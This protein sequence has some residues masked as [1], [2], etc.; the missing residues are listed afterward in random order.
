VCALL[1]AGLLVSICHLQYNHHK[2]KLVH[3][4]S[5]DQSIF[6]ICPSQSSHP[7]QLGP[8][9]YASLPHSVVCVPAIARAAAAGDKQ[10][11]T[12]T[13]RTDLS[14]FQHDD[15]KHLARSGTLQLRAYG[16]GTVQPVKTYQTTGAHTVRRRCM[17]PCTHLPGR[18]LSS[19]PDPLVCGREP[20]S[21][22]ATA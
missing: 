6:F 4:R 15:L 22:C 19:P 14:V 16:T 10:A 13:D 21:S 7:W 11:P 5:C 3:W 17:H 1:R 12:L 2:L 18:S 8:S 20:A 9:S